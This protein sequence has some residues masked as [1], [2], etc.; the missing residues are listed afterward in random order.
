MLWYLLIILVAYIN[1]SHGVGLLLQFIIVG[2]LANL[3]S[4]PLLAALI[5]LVLVVLLIRNKRTVLARLQQQQLLD[6]QCTSI[7][8]DA[9]GAMVLNVESGV[10]RTG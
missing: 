2:R 1:T 5:A 8:S 9:H 7:E 4:C 3:P 10:L 6:A